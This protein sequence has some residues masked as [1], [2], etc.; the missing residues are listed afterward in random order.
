M[1]E[2]SRNVTTQVGLVKDYIDS[3]FSDYDHGTASDVAPQ[4]KSNTDSRIRY[5]PPV[6]NHSM[7]M[8]C[9]VAG[10]KFCVSLERLASVVTADNKGIVPGSNYYLGD[11][12]HSGKY[13]KVIDLG[14]KVRKSPVETVSSTTYILLCDNGMALF[15]DKII[16]KRKIDYQF[17]SWRSDRLSTPWNAGIDSESTSMVIDI[18]QLQVLE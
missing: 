15:C 14:V 1:I 16:D 4:E 13:Y 10:R 11:V 18:D 7:V 5:T 9:S 8:E 3:F 6:A 2:L 12:S 17:V